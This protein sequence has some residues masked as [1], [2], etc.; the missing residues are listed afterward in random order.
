MIGE[1][2]CEAL[3][4]DA[5]T[6]QGINMH[7]NVDNPVALHAE[8]GHVFFHEQP[9]RVCQVLR[10]YEVRERRWLP[11]LAPPAPWVATPPKLGQVYYRLDARTA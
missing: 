8:V 2:L 7:I 3:G 1:E 10:H 6:V 5:N 11:P 9:A 4:L